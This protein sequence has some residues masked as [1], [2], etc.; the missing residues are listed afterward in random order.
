MPFAEFGTESGSFTTF[1]VKIPAWMHDEILPQ[2]LSDVPVSK[3]TAISCLIDMG[4]K[5]AHTADCLLKLLDGDLER[6]RQEEWLESREVNVRLPEWGLLFLQEA[7]EK[8]GLDILVTAILL[9]IAPCLASNYG[10]IFCPGELRIYLATNQRLLG[11]AVKHSQPF[12]GTPGI[13][14]AEI[15]PSRRIRKGSARTSSSVDGSS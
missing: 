10:L 15:T 11:A 5:L 9:H 12:T 1:N 8:P 6:L 3:D 7:G 14:S 4:I 2:N 13:S